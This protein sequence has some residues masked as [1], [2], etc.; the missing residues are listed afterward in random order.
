MIYVL[1]PIAIGYVA[2]YYLKKHEYNDLVIRYE[3]L[4]AKYEE[5][6]S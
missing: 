2:H 6:M 5:I 3:Y 4:S 1:I